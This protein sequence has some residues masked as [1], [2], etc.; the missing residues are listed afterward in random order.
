MPVRK[1]AWRPL[2]IHHPVNCA[3]DA[4]G[5]AVSSE[6]LD[7]SIEHDIVHGLQALPSLLSR[8]C[9]RTNALKHWQKISLQTSRAVPGPWR[10]VPNRAGRRLKL[11]E[12]SYIH[13]EA[14]AAGELNTVRWH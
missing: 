3:V 8:C 14:Y 11:K 2:S 4:G 12:I 10:S 1:L 13:A 6:G 7:A 9:L 5:E